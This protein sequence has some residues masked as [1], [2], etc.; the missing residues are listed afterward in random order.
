MPTL[1]RYVPTGDQPRDVTAAFFDYHR[2]YLQELIALY[3]T[4]PVAPRAKAML[5]GSNLPQ[6]AR[7]ELLVFDFLYDNVDVTSQPLDGMGTSHYAPGI[8]QVYARSGWDRQATWI[9][10][11]AGPYTEAHAHQDQ[12]SLLI[13]KE[14]WL[15]AD[16]VLGQQNGILQDVT[17]H[18]LVRID[19]GGAPLRQSVNTTSQLV[20]LHRGADWLYAAADVTAA[21]KGNPAVGKVQREVVFL[22][23]NVVIVYDRVNTGTGTSQVWQLAT[24]TR[25]TL[26]GAI[27]TIPGSHTLAVHRLAPAAAASSVYDMTRTSGYLSGFRLDESVAGGDQ[28]YLHVLS[29]DGAVSSAT[30]SGDSSVTVAM[31]S[32]QTATVSFDRDAIGA[33]MMYGGSTVT[34]GPGVDAMPE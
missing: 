18:S 30:A 8:G 1:D 2:I 19:S 31:T 34:L 6:L 5:D 4:D 16:A 9:N 13:Y 20:G 29:L 14:G 26:S 3:P 33:S 25:P 24:P 17:S 28:R 10:L 32:G 7:P 12:G 27:V 21:Y 22:Q 23:P 15:A 11:I